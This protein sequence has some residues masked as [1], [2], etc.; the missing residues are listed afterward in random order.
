MS[1][2]R[3]APYPLPEI[4]AA[5]RPARVDWQPD[6]RRAALLVHDLQDYFLDFYARDQSPVAPMLER[7]QALRDAC[8]RLDVPVYYTA[9]PAEQ[10]PGQRGLLQDWW[11]SGVTAQPLRAG[12]EASI[13]PRKHHTVLTKWRYSAFACSDLHDR[14]RLSGRDQLIVCGV[15]AHI[16]CMTTALD[17]FMRDIQPFMVGDAV[18][19]FDARQHAMALD[20]VAGRCGVVLSTRDCIEQLQ[21]GPALPASLDALRVELARIIDIPVDAIGADD[22]PLHVGLDSIRLMNLL[23]RWSA[24]GAR[25]GFVELAERESVADW[26]ALIDARREATP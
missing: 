24:G 19:D 6:A 4:D 11:G 3:I 18:A 10:T 17:A 12:I 1:I 20:Y 22:N 26:W 25:I 2:P 7:V 23:E 9:Q 5:Q 15:Y 13:A 16:G 14:L 21:A 8:D